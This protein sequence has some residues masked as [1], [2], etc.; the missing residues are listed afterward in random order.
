[1]IDVVALVPGFLGFDHR[2]DRTYFADRFIAG[3][4]ANLEARCGKPVPV[5]S[6]STLPIGSLASRQ[7]KLMDDLRVLDDR[8]A[9]PRWHL[10]G[11]ST[12][13]LDATLLACDRRLR[14]EPERGSE[15]TDE[16][17]AFD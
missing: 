14:Y 16:K 4:R 6:V 12:G 1:M 8:F 15:F 5:V 9:S 13:G 17:L 7:K 10:L 2:G 3:L 11:H